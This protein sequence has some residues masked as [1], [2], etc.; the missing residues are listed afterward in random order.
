[1]RQNK[2]SLA[3]PDTI[4]GDFGKDNGFTASGRKD[5][6]RALPAFLPLSFYGFPGFLLIRSQFHQKLPLVHFP[7]LMVCCPP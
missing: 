2:N 3:G 1:M 4:L 5:Q 6:Q 7:P